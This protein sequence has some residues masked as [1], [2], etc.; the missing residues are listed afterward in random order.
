LEGKAKSVVFAAFLGNSRPIR[1]IQM[2]IARQ[3]F[4][5]GSA[6]IPAEAFSLFGGKEADRL[7]IKVRLR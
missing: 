1:I 4:R 3:V 2:E 6:L 7:G 5:C